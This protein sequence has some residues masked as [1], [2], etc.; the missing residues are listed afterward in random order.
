MPGV[1][2]SPAEG[3]ALPGLVLEGDYQFWVL[4]DVFTFDTGG[5]IASRADEGLVVRA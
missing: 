1:E 3:I 4:D 5:E 2:P